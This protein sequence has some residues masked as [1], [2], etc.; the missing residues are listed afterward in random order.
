MR[1]RVSLAWFDRLDECFGAWWTSLDQLICVTIRTPFYIVMGWER[2]SGNP[3]LPQRRDEIRLDPAAAAAPTSGTYV[4]GDWVPNSA[5][6]I[7]TGKVLMG[8]IRLT[9]GSGNV[10]GTDWTPCYCTTS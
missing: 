7:A 10:A 1:S 3:S 8:W 6:V 2:L 4:S 9:T 5:P